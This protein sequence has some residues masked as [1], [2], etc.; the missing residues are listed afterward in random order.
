MA[1]LPTTDRPDS[2]YVDGAILERKSAELDHSDWQLEIASYLRERRKELGLYVGISVRMQ[3]SATHFRIP[4]ISV[5]LGPRPDAQIL[6]TP[7]FLCVEVLTE[8]DGMS[9]MQER[10]IDYL[11][12]GVKY[13]WVVNPLRRKGSICTPGIE[14]PAKDG[15]L[16]T[17]NPE[18]TVPLSEIYA[19]IEEL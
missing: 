1:C 12:F 9:D 3:I 2:E 5:V 15:I 10:L 8:H 18:I 11:N 6:R 7:P 17:A 13:V 14:V 19:R 4:D 16:R